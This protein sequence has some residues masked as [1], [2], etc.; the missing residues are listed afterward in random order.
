MNIEVKQKVTFTGIIPQCPYCQKPTIR[1]KGHGTVSA[2]FYQPVY[3]KEG[4]NTNPDRNIRTSNWKCLECNNDFVTAGN[5]T[6]GY[7]YK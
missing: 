5:S 2:A 3:D 1:T 6:D 4:K 7:F